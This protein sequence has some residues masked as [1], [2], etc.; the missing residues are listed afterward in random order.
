MLYSFSLC[1]EVVALCVGRE[2]CFF[3]KD[4][5]PKCRCLSMTKFLLLGTPG[6][7]KM[8]FVPQENMGKNNC[9]EWCDHVAVLGRLCCHSA[10]VM[11]TCFS[12]GAEGLQEE[13]HSPHCP[14][15][16]QHIKVSIPSFP[17][18]FASSGDG[19]V[20]G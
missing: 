11:V 4:P 19:G 17:K 7:E 13:Q 18:V 10:L 14:P 6:E 9:D 16:Q 2:E 1:S 15:T 20:C 3:W 12:G 5:L 8:W